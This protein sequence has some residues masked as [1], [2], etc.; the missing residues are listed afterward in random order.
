MTLSIHGFARDHRRQSGLTNELS[1]CRFVGTD[2][3]RLAPFFALA[4]TAQDTG[5]LRLTLKHAVELALKNTVGVLIAKIDIDEARRDAR[6]T[7][8][9]R[10]CPT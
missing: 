6:A 10:S 4:A 5:T 8:W 7:V 3:I 1:E 2:P 9:P